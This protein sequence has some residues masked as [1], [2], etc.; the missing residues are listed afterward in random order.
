MATTT[1]SPVLS[2]VRPLIPCSAG[3]K[4]LSHALTAH[5]LTGAV[6]PKV[7]ILGRE[8]VTMLA[9]TLDL[10]KTIMVDLC[11]RLEMIRVA[12]SL[13]FARM[14][15]IM[16]F[17]D[18]ADEEFIGKSMS[19]ITHSFARNGRIAHPGASREYPA[20][21]FWVLQPLKEGLDCAVSFVSASHRSLLTYPF[22]RSIHLSFLV[23]R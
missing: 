10:M 4:A 11:E 13:S 22:V 19:G 2:A 6:D 1:V 20:S 15:H 9:M 12:A 5:L 16:A 8:F 21:A 7:G 14:V 17:G 18:R 23:R 3:L